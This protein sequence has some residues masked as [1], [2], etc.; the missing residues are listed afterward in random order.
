MEELTLLS[1]IEWAQH[2]SDRCAGQPIIPGTN[3]EELARDV[4]GFPEVVLTE[5]EILAVFNYQTKR[6]SAC[7]ANHADPHV[8]GG[9]IRKNP[10]NGWQYLIDILTGNTKESE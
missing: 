5:A 6:F 10:K 3:F 1:T 8:N 4:L 7:G 2:P 9:V